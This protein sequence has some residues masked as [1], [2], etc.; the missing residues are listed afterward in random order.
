MNPPDYDKIAH[1]HYDRLTG[2]LV[3]VSPHRAQ[4]QRRITDYLALVQQSGAS[5]CNLIHNYVSPA[6]RRNQGL[7]MARALTAQI[8]PEALCRVHGGGFAGT[9]QASIPKQANYS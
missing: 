6:E 1:R 2:E 3:L 8:W 9:I 4:W 5:S 7:V